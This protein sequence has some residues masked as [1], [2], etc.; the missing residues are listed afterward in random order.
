MKAIKVIGLSLIFF[1]CMFT[2]VNAQYNIQSVNNWDFIA[3]LQSADTS[4]T[5]L[6]ISD[7][8]NATQGTHC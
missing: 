4:L 5:K 3:A 6:Y 8:D 1:F 2:V 7:T